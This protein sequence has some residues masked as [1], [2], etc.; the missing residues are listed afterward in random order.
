[1]AKVNFMDY[2]FPVI[3]GGTREGGIN[4]NELYGTCSYIKNNLFITAGHTVKNALEENVFG[5]AQLKIPGKF[6]NFIP[7]VD[8]YIIED[9]DLAII[10]TNTLKFEPIAVKID[11]GPLSLLDSIWTGGFP[12]GYDRS[13]IRIVNRALK[14]SIVSAGP[15]M[16]FPSMPQSYELSFNC[17]IGISGAPI[18]STCPRGK[19]CV[20][21]YI[22]GNSQVDLIVNE[23]TEKETSTGKEKIYKQMNTTQFGIAISTSEVLIRESSLLH[24]P[25]EVY[26][27]ENGLLG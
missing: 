4:M 25:A 7:V 26:F 1:M 21:G 17:P 14:G 6:W 18:L 12:H 13:N 22:V 24:G 16:A 10:K 20:F 27:S 9:L 8:H 19:E 15:L 2:F 3:G 5:I 23:Y 11:P